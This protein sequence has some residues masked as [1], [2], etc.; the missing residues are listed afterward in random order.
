VLYMRFETS[1]PLVADLL[2]RHTE[3]LTKRPTG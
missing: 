1:D 3:R 2:E